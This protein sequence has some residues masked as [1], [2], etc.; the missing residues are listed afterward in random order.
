MKVTHEDSMKEYERLLATP[1]SACDVPIKAKRKGLFSSQGKSLM[2]IVHS[3]TRREGIRKALHLLGGLDRM[4]SG[5]KGEVVIKPNCNSD[6][7]F[8]RNSHPKT[9]RIIA[10]SLI[11]HVL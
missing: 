10:E 4:C 11:E 3:T 5:V 2:A 1:P 6:D 7:P 9:I 8:P